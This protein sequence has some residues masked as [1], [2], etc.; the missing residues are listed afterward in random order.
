MTFLKRLFC[1]H[2][3]GNSNRLTS[4]HR[5]AYSRCRKCGATKRG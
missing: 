2:R 5:T 1:D 4:R 3:W